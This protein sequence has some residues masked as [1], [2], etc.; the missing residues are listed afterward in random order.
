MWLRE[1]TLKGRRIE[2]EE[3]ENSHVLY[4]SAR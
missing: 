2:N 1:C 3:K 4:D